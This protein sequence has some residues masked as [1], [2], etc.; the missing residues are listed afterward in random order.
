MKQKSKDINGEAFIMIT[1]KNEVNTM[2]KHISGDCK[3]KFFSTK[4]DSN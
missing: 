1:N 2:T 4:C 3:S